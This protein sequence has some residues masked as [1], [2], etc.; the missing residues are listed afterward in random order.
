MFE[1]TVIYFNENHRVI[2]MDFN[3]M[4][5]SKDDALKITTKIYKKKKEP[6]GLRYA[7]VVVW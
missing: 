1:V 3:V 4:A 7:G 5:E 6:E 2:P